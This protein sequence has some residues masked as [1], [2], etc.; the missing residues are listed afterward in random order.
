MVPPRPIDSELLLEQAGWVRSL[1]QSLVADVHL[2]D[3][4]AQ[5]TYVAAL[6]RP[7]MGGS[8]PRSWLGT[9]LRNFHLQVL[10]SRSRRSAREQQAALPEALPGTL[11]VVERAAMHRELYEAVMSLSEP[12]RTAILL[13]FFDGLP[14]RKIAAQL[15]VPAATVHSRVQR[16]LAELRARLTRKGE[17]RDWLAALLPLAHPSGATIPGVIGALLMDVKL[18]VAIGVVLIACG[19]AGVWPLVV[20]TPRTAEESPVQSSAA[21]AEKQPPRADLPDLLGAAQSMTERVVAGTSDAPPKAPVSPTEASATSRLH[22]RV[23]DARA[24]PLSGVQ[25]TF[26]WS[27]TERDT[28]VDSKASL[29]ATSDASGVV[30]FDVD[31]QANYGQLEAADPELTT[32]MGGQWR[33]G[34]SVEPVVIVAHLRPLAGVVRDED[35]SP[36]AGA[37]LVLRLDAGFES[38]FAQLLE[39]SKQQ[40]WRTES[41]SRGEFSLPRAPAVDGARL[42]TSQEN[43]V[44]DERVAPDHPDSRVEIVLSRLRFD[45]RAIEGVVLGPAAEKVEGARVRLGSSV[46]T[47]GRDG[48]FVLDVVKEDPATVLRALKPDWLPA[49]LEALP[50]ASDARRRWPPF[51]TLRLGAPALSIRGQVVDEDDHPLG[52]IRVWLADPTYFGLIDERPTQIE[53][54]LAG[55]KTNAEIEHDEES[56]PEMRGRDVPNLF[57]TWVTTG[58]DGTFRLDG[59]LARDYR[60]KAMEAKTLAQVESG[61]FT[62]GGPAVKLIL[63]KRDMK[64]VAGRIVTH[65]GEPVSGVRVQIV[66]ETMAVKYT[67]SGQESVS[68]RGMP[69]AGTT[70]GADGRFVVEGVPTGDLSIMYDSDEILPGDRD[71]SVKDDVSALEIV[72]TA[73]CHFQVELADP[74]DRAD[75]IVVLD[76]QGQRLSMLLVRGDSRESSDER[77]LSAGRSPVLAVG[78][79][80]ATIVL[81]R[82]EVEVERH[83]VRLLPKTLNTLRY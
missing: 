2:A 72:A 76:A 33:R 56:N 68:S 18:K 58:S 39:A 17:T 9:V 23:L 26:A 62:A 74:V 31:T 15:D 41:N 49:E 40:E 47:T 6:E 32:L 52:G 24:A 77:N 69:G 27:K 57:W 21:L 55:S 63:P 50:A 1:A 65:A 5:D 45:E 70:S 51:V 59:L 54:A 29:V 28:R 30:E 79:M 37:R 36:L 67:V 38:R 12:N 13:R 3:D 71:I 19:V 61:P 7:P 22:A 10:R 78:E 64:R 53:N 83:P 46:T 4:L 82:G 48:R 11:D 35:G 34:S 8:D 20:S 14:Q 60:L 25:I 66:R 80:A 44:P 16:G 81:S 42:S 43:H 75:H 73:R